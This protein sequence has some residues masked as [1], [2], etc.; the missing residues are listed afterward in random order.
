MF[1]RKLCD[2]AK[3][4]ISLHGRAGFCARCQNECDPEGRL[5]P[6]LGPDV[7]VILITLVSAVVYSVSY[8]MGTVT[9]WFRNDT[10]TQYASDVSTQTDFAKV[11]QEIITYMNSQTLVTESDITSA[12]N[13]VVSQLESEGYTVA[14]TGSYTD[15]G[16]DIHEILRVTDAGGSSVDVDVT[17]HPSGPNTPQPE[18]TRIRIRSIRGN[19][20]QMETP[21]VRQG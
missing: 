3:K 1:I 8:G 2:H 18:A 13:G 14:V 16:G 7:S 10:V 4:Y 11:R 6:D 19:M 15:A 5:Y 17:L 9:G 21:R 20:S 12:M